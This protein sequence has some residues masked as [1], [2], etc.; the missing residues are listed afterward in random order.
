MGEEL[1]SLREQMRVVI[2]TPKLSALFVLLVLYSTPSRAALT[3]MNVSSETAATAT[4]AGPQSANG[5]AVAPSP[6]EQLELHHKC[7]KAA[8]RA[9][10]QAGAMV[11]GRSWTWRL[12]AQQSLQQLSQLRQDL[13]A[14]KASEAAFEASLSPQQLSRHDAQ[15]RQIHQ[16]I[17]H[18]EHDGDSLHDELANGSPRRWH[19]A[20]DALDMRTEIRRWVRLHNQLAASVGARAS[21]A[22]CRS[23][24]RPRT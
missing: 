2:K 7:L 16:L 21:A 24:L 12:D 11:P 4:S 15:V 10:Q 5:H 18:L 6:A 1:T 14:L 22:T 19:V 8:E 13:S 9:E 17:R 20:H 3:H 23:A